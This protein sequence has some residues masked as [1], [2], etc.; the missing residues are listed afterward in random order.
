LIVK[1]ALPITVLT[2]YYGRVYTSI[3]KLQHM[4]AAGQVRY[5]YLSTFCTHHASSV[6]AACAKPVLWIREH[7]T[8]V[9]RRAGLP[10][11]GL[12]YLLPG[13]KP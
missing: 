13:A 12:L 8:D 2:T 6:N 4:I 11:G 1:D 3:V 5:A 10:R 7:G 9:S